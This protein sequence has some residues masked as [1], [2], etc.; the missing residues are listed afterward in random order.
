MRFVLA[1]IFAAVFS[2][3]GFAAPNRIA[4][5]L[6]SRQMQALPR[7]THRL[8]SARFDRGVADAALPM[9]YVMLLTKPSDAQQTDLDQ[10]LRDRQNPSSPNFHAW[11]SPEQFADRF[12][13]SLS[14]QSKIVSWLT[15]EGLTV[16][17]P[18]R[19]RNWIAFSGT[20]GQISKTFHTSIHRYEVNGE[21]HFANATDP[22]VPAAMA[23]L[24]GGFTGLHDFRPKSQIRVTGTPDFTSGNSHYLAPGDFSTIYDVAPLAL[25]GY[26]GTGQSVAVVGQSDILA[27]DISAFRSEFG[28]PSSAPRQVL[29]GAD[30]GFNFDGELEGNLDLEWAGALAP[31]ATIYYVYATDA[32]N[33]ML[34]AVAENVAPVISVSYGA[35]END[36]SPVFRSVAQRPTP[37]ESPSSPPRATPAQRAAT[38][39]AIFPWQPTPA[40]SRSP[41]VFPKSPGWAAPCSMRAPVRTGQPAIPQPALRRSRTFRKSCGMKPRRDRASWPAAAVRVLRLR[42]RTGRRVRAFRPMAPAMCRILR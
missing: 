15:G 34:Y 10:L 36:T 18:A 30:P 28:L 11:L 4:G 40:Q 35:C 20:A 3:S 1:A 8:A 39:Q 2:L 12:G 37:R 17:A 13:L 19:G 14:D 9:N 26:D 22:S 21:M 41:P 7:N 31:K 32:F 6:D 5:A 27:S 25:A 23:E 42:S 38:L 33:A 24:V 16:H 29:F